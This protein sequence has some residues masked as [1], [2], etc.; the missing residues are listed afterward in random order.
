MGQFGGGFGAGNSSNQ[1]GQFQGGGQ[2]PAGQF[3]QLGGGQAPGGV[4]P[5]LSQAQSQNR[6]QNFYSGNVEL[7]NR[8]QGLER[9]QAKSK[10]P[11]AKT[12]AIQPVETPTVE[13]PDLKK[14]PG[15]V[16]GT[17]SYQFPANYT[18]QSRRQKNDYQDTLLWKPALSTR[19]TARPRSRLT[20]RTTS[21]TTAS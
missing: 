2:F 19:R 5:I 4:N 21:P 17:W 11:P 8:F 18:H 13:P 9:T 7:Q 20:C 1:G 10:V 14:V 12:P 16:T 6:R 15:E 3:G